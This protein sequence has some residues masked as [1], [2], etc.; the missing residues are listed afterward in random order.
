[1]INN[2]EMIP[3]DLLLLSSCRQDGRYIARCLSLPPSIPVLLLFTCLHLIRCYLETANLDGETNLKHRAQLPQFAPVKSPKDLS[4]V[5]LTLEYEGPNNSIYTFE[6]AMTLRMAGVLSAGSAADSPKNSESWKRGSSGSLRQGSGLLPREGS[7]RQ[8]NPAH[9][10][11]G[12]MILQRGTTLRNTQWMYGLAVYTGT[13][14][15]NLPSPPPGLH[16]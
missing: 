5:W 7:V 14:T 9:S 6:G 2:G 16:C 1:M 10:V 15:F 3:C 13:T 11:G 12:D 8:G 4:G